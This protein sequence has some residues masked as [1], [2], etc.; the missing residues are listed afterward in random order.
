MFHPLAFKIGTPERKVVLLTIGS[1]PNLTRSYWFLKP[2]Q[3][4]RSGVLPSGIRGEGSLPQTHRGTKKKHLKTWKVLSLQNMGKI[5]HVG[6]ILSISLVFFPTQFNKYAC[7]NGSFPQL[8]MTINIYLKPPPTMSHPKNRGKHLEI[9]A[10][11][12]QVIYHKKT[13]KN[14]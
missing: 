10:P 12:I 7:Q 9:G 11:K 13:S 5:N 1:G 4:S 8:G 2:S 6:S 14:M 3:G